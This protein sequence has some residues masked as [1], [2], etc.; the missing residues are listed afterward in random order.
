[1]QKLRVNRIVSTKNALILKFCKSGVYP[2]ITRDALLA[3]LEEL[4]R[5]NPV[6]ELAGYTPAVM[7][8]GMGVVMD[9]NSG[10]APELGPYFGGVYK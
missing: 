4:E 9:A 2:D 10:A 5:N 7:S 3:Y 6:P 8:C 1:M